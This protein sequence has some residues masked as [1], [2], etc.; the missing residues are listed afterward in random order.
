[1][2]HLSTDTANERVRSG[3]IRENQTIKLYLK[4]V[5]YIFIMLWHVLDV[6][7]NFHSF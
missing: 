7:N 4:T 6:F 2:L 1:M 5:A 3:I